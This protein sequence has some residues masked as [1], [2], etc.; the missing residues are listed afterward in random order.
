MDVGLL[1]LRLLV[2]LLVA[3]HGAQ[4]LVGWFGG[5][6]LGPV[7]QFFASRGYPRP[8]AAAVLAGTSEVGGGLLLA[9]GL[10]T[11]FAGAVVIGTMINAVA[12]HWGNGLW[13]A[14]GGFEYPLV[15]AGNAAALAFTGAGRLSLDDVLGL[16]LSGAGWGLPALAVGLGSGLAVLESRRLTRRPSERGAVSA[17]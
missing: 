10:F 8:R 14:K 15:L 4:K 1:L 3:G 9:A 11:P 6:G 7:S 17:R 13:S 2:G 12:V 16:S 5:A